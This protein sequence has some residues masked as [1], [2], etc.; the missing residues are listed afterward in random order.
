MSDLQSIATF[1]AALAPFIIY[2]VALYTSGFLTSGL[3]EALK[4]KQVFVPA[5]KYPR[6]TAGVISV[7]VTVV[8]MWLTPADLAFHSAWAYI[9][10]AVGVFIV[11][12]ATYK[13][14]FK[15]LP[16]NAA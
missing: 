7:L 14:I 12:A 10:F 9:P 13:R 3:T 2:F 6:L 16:T 4:L 8:A 1:K 5:E 15:G 11:S